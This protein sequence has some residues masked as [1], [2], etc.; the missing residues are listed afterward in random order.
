MMLP[1]ARPRNA[2]QWNRNELAVK[3]ALL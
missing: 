3:T 1:P 2:N